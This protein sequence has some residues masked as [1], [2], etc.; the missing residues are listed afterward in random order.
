MEAFQGATSQLQVEGVQFRHMGQTFRQHR[1]ALTVAGNAQ[2][3]G[4]T[5]ALEMSPNDLTY[6]PFQLGKIF[7]KPCLALESVNTIGL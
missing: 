7:S 6:P 3:A 1:S 5:A 4:E 2:M